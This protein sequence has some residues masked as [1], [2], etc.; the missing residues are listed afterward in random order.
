MVTMAICII[1]LLLSIYLLD[2]SR[3]NEHAW[4]ILREREENLICHGGFNRLPLLKRDKSQVRLDISRKWCVYIDMLIWMY[5]Y[6]TLIYFA[7]LT[8]IL[9]CPHALR[10]I[11]PRQCSDE[12]MYNSCQRP[13]TKK[14]IYKLRI[15]NQ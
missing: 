11:L 5:V 7:Y 15:N 3:G 14:C 1:C 13:K 2:V 10:H 12:L 8:H 4:H 6:Y 9:V